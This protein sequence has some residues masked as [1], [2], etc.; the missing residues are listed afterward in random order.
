MIAIKLGVS[1]FFSLLSSIVRRTFGEVQLRVCREVLFP[2][3]DG[4]GK[5]TQLE[6]HVNGEMCSNIDGGKSTPFPSS[7]RRNT[8]RGL[9]ELA[10]LGHRI[11]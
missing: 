10:F 7:A 3:A 1:A 11:E 4:C 5:S 2:T 8:G 9:H 6:C